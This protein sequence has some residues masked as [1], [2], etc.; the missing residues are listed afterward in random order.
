MTNI[1]DRLKIVFVVGGLFPLLTGAD[2]YLGKIGLLPMPAFFFLFGLFIVISS[3]QWISGN[4]S[5]MIGVYLKSLIVTLPF[6]LLALITLLW[7]LHPGANWLDNGSF[8]YKCSK[9][10]VIFL[11]AIG[12]G[13]SKTIYKYFVPCMFIA[14]VGAISSIIVDVVN[15][16]Y[17]S[18]IDSRAAGFFGNSNDGAKSVLLLTAA[19]VNWRECSFFNL[20]VLILG[21]VGIFFT[22]SINTALLFCLMVVLY[23]VLALKR[24][25]LRASALKSILLLAIIAVAVVIPSMSYTIQSADMFS[26]RVTKERVEGILSLGQGDS[27]FVEGHTRIEIAKRYFRMIMKSPI[28]GY[29]TGY[30]TLVTFAPHNMYLSLWIQNGLF[31]LI[32]YVLLLIGMFYYFYRH[33]YIP[34]VVFTLLIIGSSFF[35]HDIFYQRN[36]LCLLGIFVPLAME[37]SASRVGGDRDSDFQ[38]SPSQ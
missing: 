1:F 16:G 38:V 7:G 4:G 21:G 13:Q 22:L 20:L 5:K 24:K 19:A 15:P 10:L 30:K 28:S 6:I 12:I 32:F 14:L 36:F 17:F 8:I 34:G 18:T 31:G 37:W 35:D 23:F 33:R 26:G 29:G 11:M 27:S 9:S 25:E 2:G 3:S